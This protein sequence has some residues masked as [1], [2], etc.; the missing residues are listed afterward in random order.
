MRK[1]TAA[2]KKRSARPPRRPV[3]E[4]EDASDLHERPPIVA[5]SLAHEMAAVVGP[6]GDHLQDLVWTALAA[7][8]WLAM[9]G[10]PGCW[11][12]LDVG[13]VLKLLPNDDPF[14]RGKVLFSLAGLLGFAGIEGHLAPQDACKSLAQIEELADDAAIRDY[15]RTAALQ[16]RGV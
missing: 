3:I 1:S 12:R 15:A 14:E 4:V 2:S 16:V 13:E 7:G 11:D 6:E 5:L 8:E 10:Q 9:T